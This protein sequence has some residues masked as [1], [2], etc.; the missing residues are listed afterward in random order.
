M[1]RPLLPSLCCA[2]TSQICPGTAG[3]S[4]PKQARSMSA[5]GIPN[6][7]HRATKTF[8]S[9]RAAGHSQ[10]IWCTS[11]LTSCAQCS[12]GQPRRPFRTSYIE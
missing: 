11:T 4:N 6:R 2:A 10:K 12:C 3:R 8:R 7:C 1:T 9:L 5:V